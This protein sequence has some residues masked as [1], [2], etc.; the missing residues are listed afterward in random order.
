MD[1]YI[2]Y[3]DVLSMDFDDR[4]FPKYRLSPGDI[5]L[6]EGQSLELVGRCAIYD[7][8]ISDCCFQKTL[9]RFRPGP[10]VLP[11]WAMA[12]FQY[13]LYFGVFARVALKT[14]TM[15]HLTAVRF[16]A[17]KMPVP[18]LAVQD[19]FVHEYSRLRDCAAWTASNTSHTAG[20]KSALINTL[21]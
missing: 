1:G 17:M 19:R 2:D 6:N 14:T 5:L 8:S 12:Y 4:D 9:L 20:I 16:E 10:D 18:P 3:S 13:C 7:G 21:F 11:D 15:A